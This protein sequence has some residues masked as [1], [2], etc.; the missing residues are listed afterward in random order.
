MIRIAYTV[1]L[2]LTCSPL[3]RM[4]PPSAQVAPAKR[5]LL[6]LMQ[7]MVTL[8]FSLIQFSSEL[9]YRS[10]F[11]EGKLFGSFLRVPS[12]L[13]AV[14]LTARPSIRLYQRAHQPAL[15]VGISNGRNGTTAAEDQT[16]GSMLKRSNATRHH[17]KRSIKVG[18]VGS[19]G[20]ELLVTP[21]SPSC[22]PS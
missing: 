5:V 9:E 1:A 19:T 17:S 7:G 11:R 6:D 8:R 3:T 13:T 15:I 16:T 20:S 22:K 21:P 2:R 14:Y 12:R 18:L 10:S 4:Q